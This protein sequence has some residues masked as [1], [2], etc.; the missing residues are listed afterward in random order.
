VDLSNPDDYPIRES[1]VFC[2]TFSKSTPK[3]LNSVD[4]QD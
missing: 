4:G 3:G 1:L 2:I